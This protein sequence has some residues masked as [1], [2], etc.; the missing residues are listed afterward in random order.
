MIVPRVRAAALVL[1]ASCSLAAC[2]Y[3]DGY[4][5][6]GMSV[7]YGGGYYGDYYDGYGDYYDPYYGGYGYPSSYGWFGGYYYP[8]N[9]YYVY[10]RGGRRQRWDDNQR[11]HWEGQRDHAQRDGNWNGGHRDGSQQQGNWNGG[12]RDRTQRQGN[13]SG[14]S[15][16]QSE[17]SRSAPRQGWRDRGGAQNQAAPSVTPQTRSWQGRQEMRQEQRSRRGR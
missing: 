15:R 12:Q 1:A 8:G 14:Y 5:Y 4:G 2:A 11:R 17:V 3:D 10:D 13:W 16:N 9:G 7:G 6:G